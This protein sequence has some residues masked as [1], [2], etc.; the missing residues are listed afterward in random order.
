MSGVFCVLI[1][2]IFNYI[3]YKK[4]AELNHNLGFEIGNNTNGYYRKWNNGILEQWVNKDFNWSIPNV[5]DSL[6]QGVNV[7]TFPLAFVATP[8]TVI[9]SKALWGTGASWGTVYSFSSTNA[10]IRMFDVVKRAAG[11]TRV[12]AYARGRWK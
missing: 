9:C 3:K 1:F 12:V 4:N 5:Y 10:N 2:V 6:Y 8:D 11:S 7:W